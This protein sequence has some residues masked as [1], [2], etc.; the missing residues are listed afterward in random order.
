MILLGVK[1]AMTKWIR[2]RESG[3]YYG[4][5]LTASDRVLTPFSFPLVLSHLIPH[6]PL[7]VHL[8]QEKVEREDDAFYAEHHWENTYYPKK[9]EEEEEILFP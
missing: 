2:Q 3:N 6:L 8:V 9:K 5:Y 1:Y 4:K 7:I